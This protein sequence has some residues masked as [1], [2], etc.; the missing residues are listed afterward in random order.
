M[1]D[2]ETI[3]NSEIMKDSVLRLSETL[4]GKAEY[5]IGGGLAV[6]AIDGSDL[7]REFSD[8]DIIVP[9]EGV[10]AVKDALESGVYKFW[11][12]R[13]AHRTREDLVGIGGHHEYGAMDETNHTRIGIFTFDTLHDG[14][15]VFR[16]HF[17]EKS[18]DGVL[19]DKVREMIMPPEITKDDLFSVEPIIF[20]DGMIFTV[21]P[22]QIYLRK[23][24]GSREK[25]ISDLKKIE[26]KINPEKAAKLETSISRIETKII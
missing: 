15:I 9:E 7:D 25:D 1:E 19:T 21:T 17:G 4:N 2:L 16:Q 26:S 24:N 13:F 10:D 5:Y 6:F 22:E 14:R 3:E 23:K 11:D 20:G 12:E 8:I 18:E